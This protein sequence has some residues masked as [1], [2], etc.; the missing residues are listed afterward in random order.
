MKELNYKPCNANTMK[1]KHAKRKQ[2]LSRVLLF[3]FVLFAGIGIANA[4][5]SKMDKGAA[6]GSGISLATVLPFMVSGKFKELKG[7]ELDTF[8]KEAQPEDVAKYY[9]ELNKMKKEALDKAIE[10]KASKEDLDKLKQELAESF[11]ESTKALRD[12]IKAQ[13]LAMQKIID[14]M[15]NGGEKTSLKAEVDKFIKDNHDEIK[16]IKKAG[17]GF[18]EMKVVG[19]ITT[20]SAA[21]PDGIPALQGVQ[22]A[23]PNNVNF[24]GVIIDGLVTT[25]PTSQAS[26]AYTETIPK[27]GDYTFLAEG[28][29]KQEID[30]KIET[31]YAAPKK[32]AAYEKLTEEA[33]T[34][35]PN[36]QAI[37]YNFLLQKHNLKRENGI[38]FGD[39]TG[40]NLKGATVYGRVFSAGDLANAVVAPNFMDVVNAAITDIFTTHNYTDEMPYMANLVMI[41]PADFYIELV[42]AKNSFGMP[43]YPQASLFNRVTIGGATIIPYMDIPAGKIFVAD[44]SKYNITNYVGYTVRIGWVNDDFI[45]NQF[46]ILG[47]SRL[48]G[49]VKK[50]DEVAFLYDD[51]ATIKTA[52]EKV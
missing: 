35:I 6:I 9:D 44:M 19:S 30:F 17:Q 40:D 45:K 34:D 2:T 48:H 43:L 50:L 10:S 23:P 26:Y 49:F 29:T 37:A 38:L 52:I 13:G 5:F 46:V 36:L 12:A 22:V 16:R 4:D 25:I 32:L 41:N 27:D 39:G 33:V 47:E 42:S 21:V 11:N 28:G 18:I 31:R 14:G 7:E 20:G 8:L 51:I 24:R 15:P 3:V 1:I